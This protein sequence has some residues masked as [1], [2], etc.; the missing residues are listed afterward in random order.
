MAILS[1]TNRESITKVHSSEIQ[2]EPIGLFVH[3]SNANTTDI[4]SNQVSFLFSLEGGHF[5]G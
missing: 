2:V 1:C 4:E 3:K 5:E